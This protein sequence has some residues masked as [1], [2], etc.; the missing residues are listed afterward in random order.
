MRT[1][2]RLLHRA[3]LGASACGLLAAL[4]VGL[5]A[6]D[7]DASGTGSDQRDGG[8][9]GSRPDAA[10][11][12]R[13]AEAPVTSTRFAH[14][15]PDLG[16]V[17]FCYRASGTTT[18]LGPVLGTPRAAPR[19]AG[20][21]AAAS[22]SPSTSPDADA[23]ADAA[24]D[25]NAAT[26]A[27]GASLAYRE[28]TRYVG[29]ARSG[30]LDIAVVVAGSSCA[31]P[32]L[33]RT[34]TLDPG[35]L[36]TVTV[37][38]RVGA[39]AGASSELG[40]LALVD[41]RTTQ[42]EKARVRLVHAALPA[43]GATPEATPLGVRATSGT[44]IVLADRIDPRKASSPSANV[45][46]DALGYATVGA[47]PPPAS[48]SVSGAA[49]GDAAV[50][51]WESAAVDL[52]LRGGSLHTGFVVLGDGKPFEVVWCRDTSTDG[53]LTACTRVR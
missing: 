8:E 44:T 38:G 51:A 3:A 25:A 19:D 28:V 2:R 30:P 21:D 7:D 20:S 31:S 45:P 13:D 5:F 32:L 43:P 12:P 53:D 35:K 15:A 49:L 39:D 26:T 48:L 6:C 14:F 37:L 47:L 41:D 42:P 46:V 22:P 33:V 18:F 27:P 29:L 10:V 50:E 11:L 40:L 9:L 1:S 36:S 52:D 24:V 16:R 4:P 34:V 17:D 23:V